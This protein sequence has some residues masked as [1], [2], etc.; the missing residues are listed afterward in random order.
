M[1]GNMM[2]NYISIEKKPEED[3][4]YL[5]RIIHN[6]TQKPYYQIVEW[7]ENDFWVNKIQ[8]S[9]IGETITHYAPIPTLEEIQEEV[10]KK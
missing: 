8:L 9:Y 7:C 6:P 1:K 2:L 4:F 10:S 3:G 5:G